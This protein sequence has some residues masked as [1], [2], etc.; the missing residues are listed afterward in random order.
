ELLRDA[1]PSPL[2]D[3]ERGRLALFRGDC[4]A[5]VAALGRPELEQ[6]DAAAELLGVAKG[7][8][9][10][11]A[12]TLVVRDAERDVVVRLGDDEDRPLVPLIVDAAER[13]RDA[14]K[15]DLGARLPSPIFI[16]LV[17]DQFTLAAMTGLPERAAKTT[18]TIG[19]AK[20][21]RVFLVSPRA[22]PRGYPWLDTL[23]HELTHIALS[24]ATLDRAPLWL[25]E[26]IAKREETRWREPLPLDDVPPASAVAAYGMKRG[27]GRALDGLGPSV[28][29]LPSP[30]EATVVF[31][32]V[33][34]FID[35]WA[36]EVG[37]DG[38]PKLLEAIREAPLRSDV[39]EALTA[40]SGAS[41]GEWERRW[42][43]RLGR[44]EHPLPPELRPGSTP[45]HAREIGRRVRLG[46]LLLDRGHADV[47]AEQ[48]ER[49]FELAP[50]LA[51]V[52]CP[53]ASAYLELGDHP[54][55]ALL[56]EHPTDLHQSSARW[57]SLHDLL[58]DDQPR[59]RTVA[60]SLDP[61][62]PQ[63][64][65]EERFPP[66]LPADPLLRPLC[67]SARRWPR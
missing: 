1:D 25:Q 13:T 51:P 7:C 24:L 61:L 67:E 4:D 56:V 39:D 41:L 30:E 27:L 43:E 35:F 10:G 6:D 64:A 32:Q 3:V 48:L 42:R 53:L 21:G 45:P 22:A 40:V 2:L 63:V 19:I 44:D 11:T 65:C 49:A 54:S 50:A 33:S 59:A 37:E 9:R 62:D 15:R 5:A 12:A 16:E 31:A 58:F 36:A 46:E 8:A 14:L 34:S 60:L 20:F 47:A 66:D 57:W 26:G 28:A 55:A 17:R 38:L 23:A 29:M 52:R 18:G